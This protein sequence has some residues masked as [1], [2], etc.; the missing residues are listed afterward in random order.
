MLVSYL[1]GECLESTIYAGPKI[2]IVSDQPDIA[3]PQDI[4]L[5]RLN[6]V[7]GQANLFNIP[8]LNWPDFIAK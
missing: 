8:N 3:N 2:K 5:F 6:I 4:L 1:N 7:S